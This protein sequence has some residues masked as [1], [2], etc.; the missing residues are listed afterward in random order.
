MN[1]SHAR[2]AARSG[3]A[4]FAAGE[5]PSRIRADVMSRTRST[6][7]RT[8]GIAAALRTSFP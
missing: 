7:S 5:M 3:G 2:T 4:G 1:H 6:I 8:S